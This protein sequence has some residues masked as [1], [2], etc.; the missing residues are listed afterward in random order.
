MQPQCLNGLGISVLEFNGLGA[1]CLGV[2][3]LKG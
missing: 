3:G 1:H 2:Q